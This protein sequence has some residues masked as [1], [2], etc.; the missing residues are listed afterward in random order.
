MDSGISHL[1]PYLDLSDFKKSH[2]V[3]ARI[4]LNQS[5]LYV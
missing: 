2:K 3:L 5:I 1:Y 4:K